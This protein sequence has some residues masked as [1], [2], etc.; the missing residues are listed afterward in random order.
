VGKTRNDT[1][2]E[3]GKKDNSSNNQQSTVV[4][5]TWF[6]GMEARVLVE[7]MHREARRL[8]ILKRIHSEY[9]QQVKKQSQRT[10]T[11]NNI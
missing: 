8:H 3:K 2:Q 9:W 5:H 7:P 11:N 1:L 10:I 4:V 6:L